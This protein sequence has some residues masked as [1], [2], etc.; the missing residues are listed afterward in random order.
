MNFRLTSFNTM[1]SGEY[2]VTKGPLGYYAWASK[3]LIRTQPFDS[4]EAAKAAI[5]SF[6]KE[7]TP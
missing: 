2:A 6:A 7:T 3:T 4:F 5:E 1:T